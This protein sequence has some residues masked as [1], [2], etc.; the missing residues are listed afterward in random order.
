VHFFPKGRFLS[1]LPRASPFTTTTL[2]L[3]QATSSI[4]KYIAEIKHLF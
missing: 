3:W 2:T 1:S 4:F